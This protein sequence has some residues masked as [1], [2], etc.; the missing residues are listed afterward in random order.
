MKTCSVCNK[1]A[2]AQKANR[3]WLKID[4]VWF[5]PRCYTRK[6]RDKLLNRFVS[7]SGSVQRLSEVINFLFIALIVFCSFQAW[8]FLLQET[9]LHYILSLKIFA[10]ILFVLAFQTPDEFLVLLVGATISV[11]VLWYADSKMNNCLLYTSPSP[12]DGLLSRMPSSA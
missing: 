2:E 10:G 12:R 8:H 11:L 7:N 6:M 5:C 3:E 9:E 1:Q 4:L